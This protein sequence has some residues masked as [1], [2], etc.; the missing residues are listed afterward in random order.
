[1]MRQKVALLTD[2]RIVSLLATRA[3]P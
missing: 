1:M 2:D 3:S